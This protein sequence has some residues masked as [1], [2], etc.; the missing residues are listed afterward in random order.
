MICLD[1]KLNSG[2]IRV[3]MLLPS[4]SFTNGVASFAMNYFRRVDRERMHIDFA[5][6]KDS[7]EYKEEVESAGSKVFV[8]PPIKHFFKHFSECRLILKEGQ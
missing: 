5:V 3:L 4:L 1:S 6:L 8:L 7:V 2:A